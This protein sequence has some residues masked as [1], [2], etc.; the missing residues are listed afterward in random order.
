MIRAEPGL[1]SLLRQLQFALALTTLVPLLAVSYLILRYVSPV[2]L[3]SEGVAVLLLAVMILMLTGTRMVFRLITRA[4]EA[5]SRGGPADVGARLQMLQKEICKEGRSVR[6]TVAEATALIGAIPFLA[7]GY[8]VVRYVLPVQTTE[9]ILLMTLIVAVVLFL[10]IQQIQ[11]LTKRILIVAAG[12]KLVS[13]EVGMPRDDYGVDE[14]GEMST[15]LGTIADKLSTRASELEETRVFLSHLIER[16]PH[17]LLAVS[18]SGTIQLANPAAVRVLGYDSVELLGM[19]ISSLFAVREDAE[20]ILSE[21]E[22]ATQ[23]T[24]WRSK[25]GVRVPV[26]VCRGALSQVGG[27][28]GLVLVGTDLTERRQLEEE[29]RHAQ[30]MEAIGLLAGGIAHDFNNILT[31]IQGCSYFLREGF[32]RDDP[33]RGDLE[34][35]QKA[36]DRAASLTYQLL[37]FS[38]KQVLNPQVINL[39]SVISGMDRLLRR[40]LGENI[41][42]SVLLAPDIG[43]VK[44]DRGQMEQIIVNLAINARDAM[45]GGG[46]LYIE[47]TGVDLNE[48]Y[49]QNH[50]EVKSGP[51][52]MISI[53]DKGC[54]MD[55]ELKSRIF[56]PFFTTKEVGKGSGLGL[57][58]VYGIVKQHAGHIFVYS[59]KGQGTTF[60]ICIPRIAAEEEPAVL[61]VKRGEVPHGTETVLL[62]EDDQSILDIGSRALREYGYTVLSAGNGREAMEVS[63][64]H[65][66][67]IDILITD[68]VMPAMGGKELADLLARSRSGLKTIFTSGYTNHSIAH[69]NLMEGDFSFIQ[70][71]YAVEDLLRI[72]RKILDKDS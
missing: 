70:K 63:G 27:E 31:V 28:R 1:G 3:A 19:N 12:T 33:R 61:A 52:V 17:P 39:N 20:K 40:L 60:K 45:D 66:G 37:A 35:L 47:S 57:S 23:E 59:E 62:V 51:Y 22:D 15:D 55:D 49:V 21:D 25:D 64:R 72:A 53:T 43:N 41:E 7:L 58:T 44:A 18:S 36:I 30:K 26:S 2:V 42:I 69:G 71:P 32:E 8:V 67:K 4:G 16:L 68:M 50:P 24:F 34:N 13:L 46:S 65:G 14:I 38:K 10:G 6:H 56:E 29:L 9:N 11:Q 5:A 48:S 54:G